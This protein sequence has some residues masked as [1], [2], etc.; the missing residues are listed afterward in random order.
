MELVQHVNESRIVFENM[1]VRINRLSAVKACKSWLRPELPAGNPG[2][3][4]AKDLC[5][6]KKQP[7][8]TTPV[9]R[10]T[11]KSLREPF[12]FHRPQL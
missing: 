7:R 10:L 3:K 4:L 12:I 8:P 6:S 5:Q 9:M 1:G 11:P 2:A